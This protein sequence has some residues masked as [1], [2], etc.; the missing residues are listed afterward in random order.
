MNE[1]SK[2]IKVKAHNIIPDLPTLYI[3]QNKNKNLKNYIQKSKYVRI[4]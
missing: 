2:H 3:Q 1:E 4:L